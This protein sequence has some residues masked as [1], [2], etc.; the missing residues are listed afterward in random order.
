MASHHSPRNKSL[1]WTLVVSLIGVVLVSWYVAACRTG[2]VDEQAKWTLFAT[3]V[4][5]LGSVVTL[6]ILLVDLHGK[7]TEITE[8]QSEIEALTTTLTR[9]VR[10]QEPL[11]LLEK[12]TD[13]QKRYHFRVR[14]DGGGTAFL[15]GAKFRYDNGQG[16]V[17]E[18]PSPRAVLE[19]MV[20]Q[21][22]PH[23]VL[24]DWSGDPMRTRLE[25][26][27]KWDAASVV[28]PDTL[29]ADSPQREDRNRFLPDLINVRAEM[30]YFGLGLES[31]T[32]TIETT[33]DRAY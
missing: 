19:W 21:H 18:G 9:V 1:L 23:V 22:Y 8:K 26:G 29:V 28:V 17:H 10:R 25:P 7:A 31:Q 6:V 13:D 12:S 2:D 32:K 11:L 24:Q 27:Q 4:Q 14:N 30:T 3:L 15:R 16:T 33:T 5:G 20:A